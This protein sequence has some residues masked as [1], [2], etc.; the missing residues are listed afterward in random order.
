MFSSLPNFCTLPNFVPNFVQSRVS[1]ILTLQFTV[2]YL[3]FDRLNRSLAEIVQMQEHVRRRSR[4][5]RE[6]WRWGDDGSTVTLSSGPEFPL[7]TA[8]Q[9]CCM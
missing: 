6:R 1:C 5:E 2:Q 4:N 7:S 8:V 9:R 3:Y